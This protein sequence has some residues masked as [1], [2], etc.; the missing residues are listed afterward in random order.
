VTGEGAPTTSAAVPATAADVGAIVL[1]ALEAGALGAGAL[2]V[3]LEVADDRFAARSGSPPE[4]EAS[5]H[6]TTARRIV[7]AIAIQRGF[8]YLRRSNRHPF[9]EPL[10]L[11]LPPE[12][13]TF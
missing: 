4:L 12:A 2:D 1:G 7:L 10:R 5:P 9:E 6:P 13:S 11:P 3:R 8:T